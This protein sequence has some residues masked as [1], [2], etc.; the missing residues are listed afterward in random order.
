MKQWGCHV[1]TETWFNCAG[2]EKVVSHYDAIKHLWW[3]VNV[4][5]S[6]VSDINTFVKCSWKLNIFKARENTWRHT[7]RHKPEHQSHLRCRQNLWS[8][9]FDRCYLYFIISCL[10]SLELW[11]SKIRFIA[12][13]L[14]TL[15]IFNC[16]TPCSYLSASS[17]LINYMSMHVNIVRS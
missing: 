2:N 17:Y 3:H 16:V 14:C 15:L 5:T 1:Y 10:A 12:L 9:N 8:C 4:E 6:S 7:W 11:N 13:I